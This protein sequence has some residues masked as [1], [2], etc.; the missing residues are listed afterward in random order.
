MIGVIIMALFASTSHP[1]TLVS[2]KH[3]VDSLLN[4]VLMK[5]KSIRTVESAF[6]EEA[7]IAA[8]KSQMPLRGQ[9]IGETKLFYTP[10]LLVDVKHVSKDRMSTKESSML[11]DLLEGELVLSLDSFQ[12]TSGFRDCINSQA[13]S[14]DFYFLH[15]LAQEESKSLSIAQLVSICGLRENEVMKEIESLRRRHLV[16]FRNGV[17]RLHITIPFF[18]VEP[19][20]HLSKPFVQKNVPTYSLI[21]ESFSQK[22]V[23]KCITH[24]YGQDVAVLHSEFV[25]LPIWQISLQNSDSSIQMVF[26]NAISGN[27]LKGRSSQ[28]LAKYAL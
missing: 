25:W 22:S 17:V 13:N 14:K 8:V 19:W 23:E 27:E 26:W 24:A 15:S 1:Q 16:T 2:V 11:W 21:P 20:T 28:I 12:T 5:S 18:Q 6:G 7:I 4:R 10:F 9:T 3:R